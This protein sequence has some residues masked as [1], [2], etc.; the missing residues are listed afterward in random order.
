ML[1]QPMLGATNMA[2]LGRKPFN[3]NAYVPPV[4]IASSPIQ[5]MGSGVDLPDVPAMNAPPKHNWVGIL[6][7]ALSGLAG[8]G[9]IYAPM[10]ARRQDEQTAFE[11]GEQTYQSHHAQE[12]ADQ[13][14]LLDY[15]RQNPDDPLTQYLDLAGIKDPAQRQNYY[16]QKADAMTAPPMMSASGVDEQG[17]PVMRFFPRAQPMGPSAAPAPTVGTVKNGYRFKG[18]NPASPEA[19]E[20]AG[21]PTQP[22]SGG[23]PR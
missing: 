12:L 16:R 22:A 8:N 11:R 20:P 13:M 18:G 6:A 2:M 19:W 9:P 17:N 23:F 4:N 5:P 1:A 7:D 15:K 3:P 14:R 10:A 21:G